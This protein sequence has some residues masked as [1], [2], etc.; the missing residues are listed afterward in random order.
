MLE[1][2]LLVLHHVV[3]ARMPVVL[4]HVRLLLLLLCLLLCLLGLHLLLA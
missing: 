2:G 3:L 4:H 1:I